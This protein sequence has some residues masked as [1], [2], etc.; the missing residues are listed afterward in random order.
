SQFVEQLARVIWM[1]LTAYIIMQVQHGSYVHAVVQSNLAAAIGAVFGILL[2]VWFLYRRRN[3]LN[4][5]MKQSN[6]TIKI[7]TAGIFWEIINQF[8]SFFIIDYV[9]TLFYLFEYY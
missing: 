4:A 8:I 5:L 7:S 1:L 9:V 2:L 3:E 6:H